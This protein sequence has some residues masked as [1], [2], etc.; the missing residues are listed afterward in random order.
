MQILVTDL[1]YSQTMRNE[2]NRRFEIVHRQI[3]IVIL[4]QDFRY[5]FQYQIIFYLHVKVYISKILCAYLFLH[6]RINQR[7]SWCIKPTKRL[8]I[9]TLDMNRRNKFLFRYAELTIQRPRE[10][11]DQWNMHLLKRLNLTIRVPREYV[12]SIHAPMHLYAHIHE[13]RHSTT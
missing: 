3:F 10:T 4:V 11:I 7:T 8:L 2:F 1:R 9:V 12:P 13:R 5:C 6:I